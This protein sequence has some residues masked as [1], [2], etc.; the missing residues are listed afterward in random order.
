MVRVFKKRLDIIEKRDLKDDTL[1]IFLSDHGELLGEY[2]GLVGHGEV[3]VPE[4]V[5]VPVIFI[6][7]DLPEELNFKNEGV[8]RHID[9]YPTICDI[10]G[11]YDKRISDGINLFKAKRLPFVSK[12]FLCIIE[13]IFHHIPFNSSCFF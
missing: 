4:V 1:I 8:L 2:G 5:Y 10:I 13:T 9:L 12:I 7:P 6:H 3:T 11:K